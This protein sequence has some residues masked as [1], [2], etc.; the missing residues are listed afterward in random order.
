MTFTSQYS[1]FQ[2]EKMFSVLAY[3]TQSVI[4]MQSALSGI[5]IIHNSKILLLIVKQNNS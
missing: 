3:D 2:S 5:T 1:W 4:D